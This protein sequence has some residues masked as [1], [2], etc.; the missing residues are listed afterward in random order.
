MDEISSP[1]AA[2]VAQELRAAF[3]KLRRRLKE[4]NAGE[5]TPSQIAVILRLEKFGPST[6]SQ[7]A[8]AEAMRPQS[9]GPVI[10]AL[11]SAG[12]VEGAPDP[13]D[14]R[15]TLFSLTLSSR[16]WI[17]RNRAARQD[18]LSRVIEARLSSAEQEELARA[19]AL[20]ERIT[21]D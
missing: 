17:D 15:Q 14:G 16:V 13:Q 21:A 2:A 1:R 20:L 10:T 5:L 11:E 19:V 4:Q 12:L 6:S 3:G 8:R 9:M 7:L 18:W